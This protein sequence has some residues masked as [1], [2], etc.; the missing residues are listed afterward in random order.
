MGEHSPAK[1]ADDPS[2]KLM[3]VPPASSLKPTVKGAAPDVGEA[4]DADPFVAML[5][6]AGLGVGCVVGVTVV[7]CPRDAIKASNSWVRVVTNCSRIAM[8]LL[9]LDVVVVCANTIKG[10]ASNAMPTPK[11]MSFFMFLLTQG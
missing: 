4:N 10:D 8:I 11:E 2:P 1:L 5:V 9:L 7:N 3:L 6:E